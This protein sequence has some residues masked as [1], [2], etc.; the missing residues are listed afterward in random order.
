MAKHSIS[1]DKKKVV[2]NKHQTTSIGSSAN[3][4]PKNKSKRSNWK[5]YRGQGKV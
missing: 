4:K 2:L 5:P 3:S 1:V